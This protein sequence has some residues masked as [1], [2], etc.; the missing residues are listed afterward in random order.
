M[1]RFFSESGVLILEKKTSCYLYR[2]VYY[3]LYSE[4]KKFFRIPPLIILVVTQLRESSPLCVFLDNLKTLAYCI[5]YLSGERIG[6]CFE[7]KY[8]YDGE[9]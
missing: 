5:K 4:I 6:I 2:K 3:R 9:K 8:W 7:I 1:R